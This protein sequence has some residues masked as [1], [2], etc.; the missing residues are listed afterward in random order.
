MDTSISLT[1]T[2]LEGDS[3]TVLNVDPNETVEN[4]KALIEAMV[5]VC[6]LTDCSV[7]ALWVHGVVFRVQCV[8]VL[9][10]F[11]MGLPLA[12]QMVSFNGQTLGN[13]QRLD[14]CGVKNDD[15]IMVAL[16]APY[17]HLLFT[18]SLNSVMQCCFFVFLFF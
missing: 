11:Q 12:R 6:T 2:Y 16:S 5:R 4:V 15:M 8:R 1:V 7:D 17:A 10:V 9:F 18:N 13:R 3:S 14:A